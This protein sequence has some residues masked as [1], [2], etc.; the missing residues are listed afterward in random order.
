MGTD[1]PAV[2]ASVAP[3]L[4]VRMPEPLPQGLR[5]AKAC[6]AAAVAFD[7]SKAF[8]LRMRS[9]ARLNR[10]MR[11]EYMDMTAEGSVAMVA[12]PETGSKDARAGRKGRLFRDGVVAPGGGAIADRTLSDGAPMDEDITASQQIVRVVSPQPQSARHSMQAHAPIAQFAPPSV[13][14]RA[15]PRERGRDGT[16]ART[17]HR[18][19][20]AEDASIQATSESIVVVS[21]PSGGVGVTTLSALIARELCLRGVACAVVDAAF[22]SGGIDVLLGME[23]DPGLRFHGVK[24]PLGQIEG[25]ALNRELPVWEGVPILACDPWNGSAPQ[26]WQIQSV[27]RALAGVK[28]L[29]VVDAGNAEVCE[30]IAE[31][32]R[33]T[34]IVVA[35]LSVL[36]L[37]RAKPYIARLRGGFPDG[38]SHGPGIKGEDVRGSGGIGPDAPGVV[39]VGAAPAFVNGNGSCI[40]IADASDYLECDVMGPL[41]RDPRV[42]LDVFEGMGI[43]S[44]GKNLRRS[45]ALIADET[46]TL[47]RIGRRHEARPI[48]KS[49]EG[50]ASRSWGA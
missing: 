36:G 31:L 30:R 5:P 42:Q 47:A 13:P 18:G 23:N 49:E 15:P 1:A 37:A 4:V 39:V 29:I 27:L 12:S 9:P 21:S 45:I 2:D 3:L 8:R 22:R 48:R 16:A 44:M 46:E 19:G 32:S 34:H 28:D 14:H 33:G 20:G 7:H 35:E 6:R 11:E 50:L 40:S 41:R 43:R 38:G 26:W 24:A 25:E 17:L 10:A